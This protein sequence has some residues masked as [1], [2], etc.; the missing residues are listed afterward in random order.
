ME[1][2]EKVIICTHMPNINP[3]AEER[4]TNKTFDV[5]NFKINKIIL[6]FRNSYQKWISNV[7]HAMIKIKQMFYGFVL[8]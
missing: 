5:N 4:F 3:L 8:V 7:M 1:K 6:F 2:K